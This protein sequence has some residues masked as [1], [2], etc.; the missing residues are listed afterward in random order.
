MAICILAMLFI[1]VGMV[2]TVSELRTWLIDLHKPLGILILCLAAIRACIRLTRPAPALPADLPLVQ[3][4]A[5]HLSHLMLYALI[6]RPAARRLGNAVGRRLSGPAPSARCSCR[7]SH[8]ST[9]RCSLSCA[10]P[11]PF[12][13]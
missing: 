11:T 13:P 10:R 6:V 12:S 2:S 4:M 8:P 7:P 3:R 1:G 9:G 5:A